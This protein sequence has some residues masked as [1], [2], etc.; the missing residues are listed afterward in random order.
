M[1][2]FTVAGLY[3]GITLSKLIYNLEIYCSSIF[4][5][6]AGILQNKKLKM[7]DIINL[8]IF[9]HILWKHLVQSG[10]NCGV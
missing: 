6:T 10:K 1:H 5:A 9:V 7:L 8:K 4:A 3:F 2:A